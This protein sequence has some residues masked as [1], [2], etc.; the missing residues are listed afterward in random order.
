MPRV[1]VKCRFYQSN[2][3]LRDIGGMLTYIA[4]REGVDKAGD[5]WETEPVSKAQNEIILRFVAAYPRLKKTDAYHDYITTKTKGAASEFIST[6]LETIPELLSDK[7][8]LEYMATRPRVEKMDGAHGLFSEEGA[9]LDLATEVERMRNHSGPVFTV[10]VSLKREDAER[11]GYHH[12]EQWRTLLRSKIDLIAKAHNIPASKLRWYGAFHNEAHHPHIHLMLY[13]TDPCY[14]GRI[15]K[16]GIADLHRLFGTEIF[17]DELKQIYDT[18][19]KCRNRINATARDEIEELADKIRTGL[20]TNDEFV[21]KFVALAKRLQT[22]KGKKVYG[23]LPKAIRQQVCELVDI[24]ERD[25]DIARM[26]ELWYQAKCAVYHTY[27]DNAPVKKPLSQE[28]AFKPIR[29]ALIKEADALG[30]QLLRM[31]AEASEEEENPNESSQTHSTAPHPSPIPTHRSTD[32]KPMMTHASVIATAVT[33][34]A[35]SL[36]RTFRNNFYNQVDKSPMGVD[37]RL[38]REIEAKKKGQN[39]AM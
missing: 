33:R 36:S 25:G 18:Q 14:K 11:L 2:N 6:A 30:A 37:S 15:N 1:I 26:Y 23:Y 31:D 19:T 27:T 16:N 4:T 38:H 12:A 39:L 10:I 17:R 3:S 22:V 32:A 9:P 24:L 21:L 28:E 13:S 7:T 29:N 8:Y 5:G 35:G 34:F 20:A